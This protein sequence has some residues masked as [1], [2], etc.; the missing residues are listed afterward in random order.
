MCGFSPVT[1]NCLG[2]D[3]KKR[4]NL[5]SQHQ[6]PN[7]LMPHLRHLPYVISYYSRN[8]RSICKIYSDPF[9]RNQIIPFVFYVHLKAP[10]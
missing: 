5:V 8:V 3:I 6:N 1:F 10:A 7:F 9:S 2:T 4:D